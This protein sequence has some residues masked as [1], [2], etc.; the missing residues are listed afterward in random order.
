MADIRVEKREDAVAWR[1]DIKKVERNMRIL[2]DDGCEALCFAGGNCIAS[3]SGGIPKMLNE[4][5][6]LQRQYRNVDFYFLVFNRDRTA[7]VKWGVGKNPVTY[8]DSKLEGAMISVSAYGH[9]EVTVYNA[10]D[11][12]ESMPPEA[13]V[14][15]VIEP[16]EVAMHIQRD[17]ISKIGPIISR[18]LN[19]IGD[20]T[21]VLGC[22]DELNHAILTELHGLETDGLRLSK[23]V[24]E[25]MDF[26]EQSKEF[27]ALAQE[28]AKSKITQEIVASQAGQLQAIIDAVDGKKE[29][30]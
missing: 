23:V 10:R 19:E 4:D 11:L 8:Q 18:K 9:C 20:Y 14:D 26:T 3:F 2:V 24:I 1:Q 17:I 6:R 29:D 5:G 22:L 12:W 15:G 30:K 7:Q 28:R 21:K 16:K 27:I 13:T 25:A